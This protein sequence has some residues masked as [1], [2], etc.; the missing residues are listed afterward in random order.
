[1]TDLANTRELPS[2][3]SLLL[4]H[5]H[6]YTTFLQ[7]NLLDI[8]SVSSLLRADSSYLHLTLTLRTKIEKL[9]EWVSEIRFIAPWESL[10]II[11]EYE[12]HLQ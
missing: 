3:R 1:M 6:Q 4:F 12:L 2:V 9:E 10:R 5:I 7:L 11:N 8:L